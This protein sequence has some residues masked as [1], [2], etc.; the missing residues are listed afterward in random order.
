M[1]SQVRVLP[2]PLSTWRTLR[3]LEA[4]DCFFHWT[5]ETVHVIYEKSFKNAENQKENENHP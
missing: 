1:A 4:C 5:F 2:T 3:R